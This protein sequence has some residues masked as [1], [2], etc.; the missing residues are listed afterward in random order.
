MFPGGQLGSIADEVKGLQLGTIEMFVVPPDFLKGIQ[1]KFQVASAPGLFDDIK[2]AQR[3]FT[4][5]D[6]RDK[7]LDAGVSKGV[8]GISI[9]DSGATDYATI[10]PIRKLDDFKGR[11]IRVLA[12]EIETKMMGRLGAAGVPLDIADVLPALQQRALDGI[13]SVASIMDARKFWTTTKY[14]TVMNDTHIPLV[15]W[16]GMPFYNK[17][18]PEHQ[19]TIERIGR[20]MEPFMLERSLAANGAA[21]DSWRKNGAEIIKL[22]DHDRAEFMQRVSGVAD[23]V[24]GSDAQLKEIYG[25]L[26]EVAAKTRQK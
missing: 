23:E 12:T 1:S 2:H 7:F 20:E 13:R 11:K 10:E 16:V 18:P 3:A 24:M 17:L 19:K 26:K 8:K 22:S 9:W 15:A 5:P 4:D 14:L 6:F 25:V 21:Y